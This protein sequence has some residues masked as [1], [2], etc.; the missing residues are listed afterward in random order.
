[1]L[2]AANNAAVG[3]DPWANNLVLHNQLLQMFLDINSQW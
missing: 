2:L 1:M 3:G